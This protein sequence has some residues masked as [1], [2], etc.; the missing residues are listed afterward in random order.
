MNRLILILALVATATAADYTI[1]L[2]ARQTAVLE[3]VAAR[4]TV[5]RGTNVTAE[6]YLREVVLID[7]RQRAEEQHAAELDG[8]RKAWEN[9]TDEEKAAAKA[10]VKA[11]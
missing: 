9:A 8:L 1:R 5:E 3:R 4:L 10:A 2:N 7:L 6:A 11:Q